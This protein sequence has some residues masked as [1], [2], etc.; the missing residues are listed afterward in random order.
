MAFLLEDI[1]KFMQQAQA[2]NE[3]YFQLEGRTL[4]SSNTKSTANNSSQS[5][6]VR[7][8]ILSVPLKMLSNSNGFLIQR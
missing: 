6:S 3:L 4:P 2:V 5:A 1:D 7:F 8:S